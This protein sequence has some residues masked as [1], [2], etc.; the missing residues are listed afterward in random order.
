MLWLKPDAFPRLSRAVSIVV[1][2]AEGGLTP[3]LEGTRTVARCPFRGCAELVLD[4]RANTYNCAA[5]GAH[6]NVI[7]LVMTLSRLPFVAALRQLAFRA[8]R[9]WT[10]FVSDRC[11]CGACR[12]SRRRTSAV[13][14]W[15]LTPPPFVTGEGR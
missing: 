8:G 15:A 11:E 6:G 4:A 1:I 10:D 5:C 2:A 3:H 9:P 13:P 12:P 14:L 7:G